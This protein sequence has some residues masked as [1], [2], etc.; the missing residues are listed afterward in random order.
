MN[1]N[2]G[3]ILEEASGAWSRLAQRHQLETRGRETDVPPGF[4]TRVAARWRECRA[5]EILA[6][7]ERI[8]LRA[9]FASSAVV[10][11]VVA[12]SLPREQALAADEDLI[13]VM[14]AGAEEME[15][16]LP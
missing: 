8:S 5:R 4:A 7:W 6:V 14:E 2:T 13:P 16:L 12:F 15:W 3:K 1:G 9:A 11:V 10:V